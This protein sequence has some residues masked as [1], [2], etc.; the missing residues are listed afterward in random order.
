[1]LFALLCFADIRTAIRTAIRLGVN[2]YPPKYIPGVST[3]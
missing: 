2:I 1:M 3:V